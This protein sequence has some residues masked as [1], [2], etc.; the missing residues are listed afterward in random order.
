MEPSRV[1]E[2]NRSTVEMT[3]RCGMTTTMEVRRRWSQ[4]NGDDGEMR[5]D[6]DHDGEQLWR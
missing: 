6:D 4:I 1:L 2:D 3:A 5:D